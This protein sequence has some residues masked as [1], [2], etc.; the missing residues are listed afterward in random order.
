[1]RIAVLTSL[2]PTPARPHEGVFAERRWARMLARGHDVR[3]VHPLP[4]A[5]RLLG[6]RPWREI[7]AA[8]PHEA[9]DGLRIARPRYLHVPRR[10]RANAHAFAACGLRAIDEGPPPEVVVADY[11][12]PAAMAADGLRG[13]RLAFVV[14]GRGSDVLQVS[15]SDTLRPLLAEALRAAGHWCAV[16]EDLVRRMDALA[17]CPGRGVLT[18]NGVDL[19]LFAPRDRAVERSRLDL[20]PRAPV[21]LVVGH[22]IQ[23]KDPLLALRA[24]ALWAGERPDALLVLVGRG[25]LRGA[26]EVHARE[27]GLAGRVRLLG[28]LPPDELAHW[29]AAADALLLTSQREGRPNVVLEALASGLPVLATPAGGTAELLEGLPGSL[30]EQ[31]DPRQLAAALASLLASP[32]AREQLLARARAH[33]WEA[34]LDA[35]EGCLRRALD[36]KSLP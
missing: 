25:P 8:P 17:H 7:A 30:C 14:H 4:R 22:L 6:P 5:S 21:V 16:S 3:V 20:P 33:S 26:L 11:A 12:W 18:P 27:L 34:G 23:R 28:E 36:G 35:L 32:P 9:R 1:V 31:R 29:Y 2:Y 19:E 10:A 15:E 13:R 24:F